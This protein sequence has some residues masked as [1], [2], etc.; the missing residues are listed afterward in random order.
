[1]AAYLYLCY[2]KIKVSINYRFE[3]V[4]SI[5]ASMIIMVINVFLWKTVYSGV[6]SIQGVTV[7]QMV[8]Y[9]I[10]SM[11]LSHVFKNTIEGDLIDRIENGDIVIDFIR[12]INIIFSYLSTDIGFLISNLL[13]KVLPM[14]IIT[15]IVY[16]ILPVKNA[17]AILIFIVS[18]LLSYLILWLVSAIFGVIGF[19]LI[20]YGNIN[21]I[22]NAI[23][24]LLSGSYI[25]IWF[26][27]KGF[28]EVVKYLPFQYTYQAPL[29]I[30]IGKYT[31][32]D[33]INLLGIQFLWVIILTAILWATWKNI[34]KFVLVQGG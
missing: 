10:L 28:K 26:F 32:N 25:P 3:V 27:P 30:Y 31:G 6:D 29:G 17:A 15:L 21:L 24:L 16:P 23:I 34:K 1:M 2:T 9:A 18:V 12:P 11:F 14:L 19:K 4:T 5:L 8:T 33:I 20:N 7:K 13:N 22:K